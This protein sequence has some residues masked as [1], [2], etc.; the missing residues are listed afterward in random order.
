MTIGGTNSSLYTGN[1]NFITLTQAQY[2]MI[3]MTSMKVQ[4][5]QAITLSG[6]NQ[7]AVIDTGTTLIG[8]PQ[9]I[10]DQMYS[11]ISGA[12]RGSQLSSSLADYYLIRQCRFNP[13]PASHILT[14][15]TSSLQHESACVPHLWRYRLPN[16]FSGF[17]HRSG[18]EH[19]LSRSVL[20]PRARLWLVPYPRSEQLESTDLGRRRLVPQERIHCLSCGS[21]QRWVCDSQ[22]SHGCY[23]LSWH[24]NLKW[25]HYH[26]QR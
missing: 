10:L 4:G 5:G 15:E 17:H 23:R 24:T 21:C 11:Q 3:P 25:D 6:S 19:L 16:L 7:N 26:C 13:P 18:L 20:H 12:V 22:F 14:S 8:G 1:I 9:S 2:W